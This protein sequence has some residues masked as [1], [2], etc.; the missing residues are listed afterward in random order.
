LLPLLYGSEDTLAPV[1]LVQ[2]IGPRPILF[3][4]GEFDDSVPR[5]MTERLYAAA[6]RPKKRVVIRGGKHGNFSR[7]A[8]HEYA[9]ALRDFFERSLLNGRVAAVQ[10]AK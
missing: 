1:H 8:A 2:R 9:R 5:F 4:E 3:I 6:A 10:S 7:V